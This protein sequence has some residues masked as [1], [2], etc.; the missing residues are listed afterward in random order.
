MNKKDFKIIFMGTPDFAVESLKSLHENGYNISAVITVPDKPSGRGQKINQSP[1][2]KYAVKN[3]ILVLQPP[4]LK[5]PEFIEQLSKINADLQVVVAFRMLPEIVWSM[6]KHGTINLHASLLPDYRGAAP[7]NHAIING[8]TKTGITTFFIEK[9]ID[10][11]EIIFRE[12]VN[13]SDNENV[14]ELHDRLM[15][16]GGELISRTVDAII[17]DNYTKVSQNNILK[18]NKPKLAPKIFKQDCK[19]N[20]ESDIHKTYNFIRGMSPYPAA[21]TEII[22]NDTGKKLSLKIF[23]CE[24]IIE[25]HNLKVGDI[26]FD[27]KNLKIV[28]SEGF[29]KILSLQLSGKKKMPTNDLLNGFNF[30]N[31][32]ISTI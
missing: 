4:K 25:N 27:K 10:T 23:E 29:I 14:G 13:I 6:P 9:E 2:K 18:G 11:G 17:S 31:Y 28:V 30:S 26:I 7:I 5:S 32:S 19:I 3:N 24:K 12:E 22:N 21:F 16:K 15:L 8:E 1:V 20:W